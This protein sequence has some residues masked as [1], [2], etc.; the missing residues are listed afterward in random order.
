[1]GQ[2]Q[3]AA[4]PSN[5]PRL[6]WLALEPITGRTHQLRVHCAA[7]GWPIIGDSIY[8]A[9][10]ANADHPAC[11]CTREKSWCRFT[12]IARRSALPRLC[13]R[14]CGRLLRRVRMAGEPSAEWTPHETGT[15]LNK[16]SLSDAPVLHGPCA[17]PPSLPS[18]NSARI[19]PLLGRLLRSTWRDGSHSLERT[20]A[21]RD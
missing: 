20:I 6:A 21:F 9:A 7:M 15:P 12:T 10:P 17:S 4:A 11:T 14:T 16:A 13:R 2:T 19:V 8:G 3:A 5:S 18:V 1:M